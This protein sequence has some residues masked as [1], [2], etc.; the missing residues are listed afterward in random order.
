MSSMSEERAIK[1]Q[2]RRTSP[3]NEDGMFT[4]QTKKDC[5]QLLMACDPETE[6][7]DCF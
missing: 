4:L 6:I 2:K 7:I 3:E 5:K 1:A